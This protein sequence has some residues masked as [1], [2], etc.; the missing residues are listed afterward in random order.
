VRAKK[1]D[2]ITSTIDSILQEKSSA[3]YSM[4]G[5]F[6]IMRDSIEFDAPLINGEVIRVPEEYK[7]DL[8]SVDRVH[9]KIS[10]GEGNPVNSDDIIS[11]YAKQP[12]MVPG[13]QAPKRDE[14]YDGR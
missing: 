4:W 2:I 12:M 10:T 11:T 14:L 5:G 1:P 6:P 13:F 8:S 3:L 9:V 7:K